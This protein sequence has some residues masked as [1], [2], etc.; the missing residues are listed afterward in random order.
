MSV[1]RSEN[2]IEYPSLR[3]E[4]RGLMASS[5]GTESYVAFVEAKA[6]ETASITPADSRLSPFGRLLSSGTALRQGGVSLIDQGVVS[7]TNFMTALMIGRACS[8]EELGI[9]MLGFTI[10]LFVMDLQA[11]LILT[12]FMVFSPRLRGSAH[13]LFTGSTLIHQFALSGLAILALMI[14]GAVVRQDHGSS[15]LAPVL[16]TLAAVI[17]LVMLR[18]YVRR[19]CFAG[20]RINTALLLDSCIGVMQL[21]GLLVLFRLGKL[22]ASRAYWVVGLSSG[23]VVLGWMISHSE[24]FTLRLS[25]SASDLRR[26]WSFGKWVF[27]SGL[28]WTLSMSLYP[29]ILAT[30]HGTAATGVW[31]AC[32]GIAGLSNPVLLGGQNYLGPKIA[33]VYASGG[34]SAF[35]SFVFK[36]GAVF[37]LPMWVLSAGMLAVG[38]PLVVFLYGSKYAGNG[39]IVFVMTANLIFSAAA[40]AASRALFAIERADLDFLVNFAALFVLLVAG[41][42]LTKFHGAFG[43]ACGV[44]LANATATAVRCVVFVRAIASHPDRPIR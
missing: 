30:Y 8:K 5:T 2:I 9:Y 20:L 39:L 33:H 40:F 18:E 34:T 37:S 44:L 21:G 43:A 36:A 4:A 19:V 32:L 12:P 13:A 1:C 25:Q 17:T 31:A 15:G 35:R 26:N 38:G 6:V 16:W 27:A 11:S 10:I 23:I 22:S 41:V 28:S 29:W 14:G 7:A 24:R 3:Y 42:W